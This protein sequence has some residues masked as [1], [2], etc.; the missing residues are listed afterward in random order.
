M[1]NPPKQAGFQK[2]MA[3]STLFTE[4]PSTAPRPTTKACLRRFF[5]GEGW[6]STR[7]TDFLER[8][9]SGELLRDDCGFQDFW[10]ILV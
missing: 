5:S 8:Q 10:I 3:F 4:V 7:T 2:T 6:F 1:A 9:K